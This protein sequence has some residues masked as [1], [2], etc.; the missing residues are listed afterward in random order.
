MQR[1][2][3]QMTTDSLNLI[4]GLAGLLLGLISAYGQIKGFVRGAAKLGVD[5]AKRWVDNPERENHAYVRYPSAFI[6]YAV[7][8]FV[9]P[10]ALLFVIPFFSILFKTNAIGLPAWMVGSLSFL[11][12]TLCGLQLGALLSRAGDVRDLALKTHIDP[13]QLPPG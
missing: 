1:H 2:G 12:P 9:L 4:L 6:A 5:R 11:M 10:L 3:T 7:R 8:R 13:A